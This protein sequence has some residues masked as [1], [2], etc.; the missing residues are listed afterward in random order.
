MFK[1][2]I[3]KILKYCRDNTSKIY[4]KIDEITERYKTIKKANDKAQLNEIAFMFIL[5]ENGFC[6]DSKSELAYVYQPN[7][8]QKTPDFRLIKY[9]DNIITESLDIEMK[10]SKSKNIY[11]N[12]GTFEDNIIYIITFIE[13]KKYNCLIAYGRDILTDKDRECLKKRRELI[14]EVNDGIKQ[15]TDFLKLYL[16]S[17]NTYSCKQFTCDFIDKCFKNVEESIQSS[18]V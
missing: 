4:G 13:Q 5:E 3:L 8:L 11:L 17:A 7:G 10:G 12:D 1:S 2:N 9:T 15:E 6:N 16:R 18:F 14:R